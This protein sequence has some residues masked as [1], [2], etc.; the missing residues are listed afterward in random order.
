MRTFKRQ[1]WL[2]VCLCGSAFLAGCQM[3]GSRQAVSQPA[4]CASA[5]TKTATTQTAVLT[6]LKQPAYGGTTTAALATSESPQPLPQKAVKQV[7][8]TTAQPASVQE[9]SPAAPKTGV[10]Y[11]SVAALPAPS[12]PADEDLPR[13]KSLYPRG[14][15]VPARKSYTDITA[16]SSF[17]HA[18][19]YSWIRGEATKWR[20][21]WRLRY[22]SVDEVDAHGGSLVLTGE[23]QLE[24]LQD[25]EHFKLEG[26]VEPHGSRSGAASFYVEAVEPVGH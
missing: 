4:C 3:P 12:A 14:E 16:H 24:N 9:D 2:I 21:E 25:G 6:D 8:V 23:H 17:G 18:E 15:Q 10:M 20:T 7:A 11:S 13:A 1:R 26:H 19:D 5:C 22:A